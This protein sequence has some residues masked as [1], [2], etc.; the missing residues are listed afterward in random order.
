MP[1][2]SRPTWAKKFNGAVT[3][4]TPGTSGTLVEKLPGFEV[5]LNPESLVTDQVTVA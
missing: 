2:R 1:F 4:L 3:P 5:K